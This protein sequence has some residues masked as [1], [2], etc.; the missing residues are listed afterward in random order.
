[1]GMSFFTRTLI[2]KWQNMFNLLFA[3]NF[4][5]Q[6]A[7][8]GGLFRKTR[9]LLERQVELRRMARGKSN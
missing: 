6:L 2:L 9:E 1:M 8:F 4:G 7:R 5:R 3:H